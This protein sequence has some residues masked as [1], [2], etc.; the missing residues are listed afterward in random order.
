MNTREGHIRFSVTVV[1][2][3]ILDVIAAGA[4]IFLIIK[5]SQTVNQGANISEIK[6]TI[7]DMT[8]EEADEYISSQINQASN[9]TTKLNAQIVYT[10][11]LS[12]RE[13]YSEAIEYAKNINN[14]Q[15]NDNQKNEYYGCLV[16]TY[17]QLEDYSN[18]AKYEALMPNP[19][20]GGGA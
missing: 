2:F 14:T 12:E 18:V 1:I 5:H 9:D 7:A 16:Y 6:D 13:R 11:T 20:M 17:L 19:P 3:V 4:L 10:C 8:E 15:M